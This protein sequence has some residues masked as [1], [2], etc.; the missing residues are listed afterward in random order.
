[1]TKY[2]ITFAFVAVLLAVGGPA[3]VASYHHAQDVAK[4][5]GET[6]EMAAWLP[7][8]TDGLLVAVLA[9]VYWRRYVGERVG[10]F[11]WVAFGLGFL[12]TLGANL[13]SAEMTFGGVAVALWPPICFALTLEL[14]AMM[15]KSVARNSVPEPVVSEPTE[16]KVDVTPLFLPEPEVPMTDLSKRQEAARWAR[17]YWPVTGQQIADK[18][19]YALSTAYAIRREAEPQKTNGSK[20]PS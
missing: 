18:F 3:G 6:E 15:L 17:E 12:A 11:P 7:L 8:T 9:L 5:Y 14:G 13:A 1:M 16:P 20:R 10:V 2:L 19:G 4:K